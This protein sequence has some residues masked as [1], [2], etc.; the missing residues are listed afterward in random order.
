[1]GEQPHLDRRQ[2][3]EEKHTRHVLPLLYLC[4]LEMLRDRVLVAM[5]RLVSYIT[6]HCGHHL[7]IQGMNG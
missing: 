3:I 7:H 1:M 5:Y 6:V 2:I 4:A